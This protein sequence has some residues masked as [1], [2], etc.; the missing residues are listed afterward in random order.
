VTVTATGRATFPA[1]LAALLLV[2]AVLAAFLPCL[3]YGFAPVDDEKNFLDNPFYRGLGPGPLRWM[4][5]TRHMGHFIPVTWL[6]LGL[7]YTLWGMRPFG[8]HLTS[9]LFHLATSV[10]FFLL[11]LR[12]LRGEARAGPAVLGALV[13]ALFFAVHPLRVESVVW[14]SERRDVVCG[15]FSVLTAHAYVSAARAS[16]ARR[17]RLLVLTCALFAAA[18]LSKGIAVALL[19]AFLALDV[20]LLRRLPPEP[21]RWFWP[22]Y[23]PVI[24]EKA[25]LLAVGLVSA[26]LTLL[27]IGYVLA[28]IESMGVG[29]R[30]AALVYSLTFYLQKTV[31]P[32]PLPLLVYGPAAA[33]LSASE[34]AVRAVVVV[35]VV[36]VLMAWRRRW[37]G[38]VA[39]AATYA[40]FVLPV[41]GVLQ[42][43]PQLV[44]HRYT[45]HSCWPWALLLG[46]GVCR[47]LERRPDDPRRQVAS[48]AGGLVLAVA[49]VTL[50]RAQSA[51][52]RDALTFSSAA[53]ASSPAAW[54]PRYTLAGVHLRAGRWEEAA[55][56]LRA[57]LYQAPTAAPLLNM[58]ALL[59]ATCPDARVRQGQEASLL[60]ERL[61]RLSPRDPWALLTY[62]AA[63][64]QNGDP[65][66]AAAVAD[67]ALALAEQGGDSMLAQRIRA[68]LASYR[69]GRPLRM[70]AADWGQD[71]LGP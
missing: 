68:A 59:L 2:A 8:Y 64:A 33:R 57:G 61:V 31:F 19:V 49:L 29:W 70:E 32:Y 44:A 4:F 40:A 54:P 66:R 46:W 71:R 15:L 5:T 62:S 43:G 14:I 36:A 67:Q 21:A 60:A 6:T 11:V 38:L 27:A 10:A 56:Q 39:A 34:V 52:W 45:Y 58:T 63:L 17:R 69:V 26:A 23:R 30:L 13:A 48:A 28:P 1:A 53:V 16:G 9:L 7:D 50:T 20:T 42:A 37:P 24:L 65:Q 55:R 25:G 12:L 41:S 47:W 18:L 22:E 51:L 35:A 3:A